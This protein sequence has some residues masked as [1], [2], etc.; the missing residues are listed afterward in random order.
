MRF[1]RFRAI[2]FPWEGH[3]AENSN[4]CFGNED[5]ICAWSS[6]LNVCGDR[7]TQDINLHIDGFNVVN[8]LLEFCKVVVVHCNSSSAWLV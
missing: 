4:S 2:A 5:A 8:L 7:F 1:T 3:A 6:H